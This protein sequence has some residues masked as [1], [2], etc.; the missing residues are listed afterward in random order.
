MSRLFNIFSRPDHEDLQNPMSWVEGRVPAVQAVANRPLDL[1][2]RWLPK[3][4]TDASAPA[5]YFRTALSSPGH[6]VC[7]MDCGKQAEGLPFD[8]RGQAKRR[9]R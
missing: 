1:T 8:S 6:S 4:G 5:A 2:V 9:P 3:S 7:E